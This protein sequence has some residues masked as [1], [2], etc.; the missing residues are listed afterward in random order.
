VVLDDE[1][2]PEAS[3]GNVTIDVAAA[4]GAISQF[5]RAASADVSVHHD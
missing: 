4:I 2:A 5:V 1:D 3:V